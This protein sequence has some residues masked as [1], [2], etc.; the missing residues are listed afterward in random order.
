MI[1]RDADALLRQTRRTESAALAGQPSTPKLLCRPEQVV[2]EASADCPEREGTD[3]LGPEERRRS[4]DA[5][6]GGQ[7]RDEV[8]AE[9]TTG[10]GRTS[11]QPEGG[12]VLPQKGKAPASRRRQARWGV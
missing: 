9:Q 10:S 2:N 11:K 8:A 6:G 7:H 12:A 3:G 5:Q 1:F 4:A